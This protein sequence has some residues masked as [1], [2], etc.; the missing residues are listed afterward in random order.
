MTTSAQVTKD[1]IEAA[2]EQ[3]AKQN[4]STEH[5][6][7]E[8]DNSVAAAEKKAGHK[9]DEN[10]AALKDAEGKEIPLDAVKDGA[11]KG[12]AD[13]EKAAKHKK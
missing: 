12:E 6:L 11:G 10:G 3:K 1:G 5:T 7:D 4:P 13:A 2:K 8:K 9:L